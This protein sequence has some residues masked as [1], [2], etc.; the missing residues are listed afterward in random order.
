MPYSTEAN[1][2]NGVGGSRNL[3]E[4]ADLE[5]TQVTDGGVGV[6]AVVVEAIREADGIINSYL[7]QR[8]AVPLAVVPDEIRALSSAWAC[9]VLRRNRFKGQPI[10]EDQDAEKIDREW[11]KLVAKGEIQLGLEPTPA[12]SSVVIDKVGTRDTAL[13]ISSNRMKDFI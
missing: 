5:D 10:S 3:I 12:A 7:R 1:V 4:L 8:F 13:L 11:L 9:R 2:R 6:S